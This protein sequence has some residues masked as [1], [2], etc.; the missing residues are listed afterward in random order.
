MRALRLSGRDGCGPAAGRAGVRAGRHAAEHPV[1]HGR[2]RRLVEHRRL[3]PRHDGRPD[4]E[5]RPLAAEG[6]LFTDYYAEASCTAG[7]ANF[8]TGELPIRTGL[9]TVGQAGAPIGMPAEAPTIATALKA[10][11]LRDR[12]VRQEP[13]RRPQRVPADGARLRR[14]LRLPLPPRRD[15]GP[16]R[17]R[18]I[19]RTCGHGRAA[20]PDAFLGDRQGRPDRG[21]ALGQGR[22]AADRGRRRTLYP[23][24]H[25]DRRRG[26]PRQGARRSSTRRRP[27][28]SRSSSG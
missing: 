4:A 3:P 15:G 22:Q 8:I 20:Q 13:P 14:V 25:G 12:A 16:V 11:G 6:M 28:T 26:D 18:T 23:E 7:R 21:P 19:R 27:T 24:Q 1:H 17:T 9:T 5:P 2:R 10:H